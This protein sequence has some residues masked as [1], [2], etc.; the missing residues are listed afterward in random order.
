[1]CGWVGGCLC[2][3]VIDRQRE[4]TQVSTPV[5]PPALQVSRGGTD[6]QG[7]GARRRGGTVE[8]RDSHAFVSSRQAA[9]A[10]AS[11]FR[12]AMYFSMKVLHS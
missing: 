1:V 9:C 12:Q 3:C 11:R 7:A 2:V 4:S 8:G 5:V 10:F 6:R